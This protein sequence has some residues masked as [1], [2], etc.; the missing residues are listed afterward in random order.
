MVDLNSKVAMEILKKNTIKNCTQVQHLS[1]CAYIPSWSIKVVV[2]IIVMVVLY[3]MQGNEKTEKRQK[4][5]CD[6][7]HS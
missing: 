5:Q 2:M 4:Q 1:K 6:T 3:Y 7:I